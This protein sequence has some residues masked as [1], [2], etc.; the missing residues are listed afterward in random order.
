MKKAIRYLAEILF[1]VLALALYIMGRSSL[2]FFMAALIL[3]VVFEINDRL[4]DNKAVRNITAII[5]LTVV[6]WMFNDLMAI[7]KFHGALDK[8]SVL[9]FII[10]AIV[11]L[12]IFGISG[13]IYITFIISQIIFVFIGVLNAVIKA[14]RRTPISAGDIFSVKTAFAVAGN[15]SM[16]FDK[17]FVLKVGVGVVLVILANIIILSYIRKPKEQTI[18]L[19]IPTRII[20][21]AVPCIYVLIMA[22]TPLIINISGKEPDYFTHE[23][24]G[25]AFNLYLQLKDMVIK[26]PEDY[27]LDSLNQL[28]SEYTSDTAES[29]DNYPNIIVIMN[30]SFADL[31]VL[32][33][34]DTSQ[35]VLPFLNSLTENTI[36]GY[37]YSSVYGGNTANSEYE[38]LTGNS[39][40]YFSERVVP[41]QLY[42][43]ETRPSIVS[44]LEQLG[45]KTTFMHP[46]KAYSWNRPTVYTALGMDS[47]YYE[48]D[49]ADLE[50]LR[51]YATDS[52]QYDYLIKY[53][54]EEHDSPRFIYDVTVQNHGGY[55]EADDTL[56]K[57]TISGYEGQYP[58]TENYLTLVH[59]SDKA[60]QDLIEYLETYEE[61]TVVLFYGDHQPS[62][63]TSFVEMAEGKSQSD[64]TLED[65]QKMYK[66][67]F[68]LWANFDIEEKTVDKMSINYL[69]T[70][71]CNEIGLPMTGFQTFMADMYEELPVINSV[72]IIDNENENMSKGDLTGARADIF[73]IYTDLIYNYMFD[74]DSRMTEFF[75]LQ[76]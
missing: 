50:I 57:I 48:E 27:N 45:Y 6:M 32:G 74:S 39:I 63:E 60:I 52:S 59:E 64:F 3:F 42:M 13:K 22:A 26:E 56:E 4:I 33:D 40:S 15:Y 66:V 21:I 65:R 16:E 5:L 47:M 62:I 2:S 58:E 70:F 28:M 9:N 69:G 71:L 31:N 10:Y 17:E 11:F 14:I 75:T 54:N 36:K 38:F 24:N 12:L 19:A 68:F 44:Q 23:T 35:E 46:Y 61:P 41:F 67:P 30:E 25:F 1:V 18:K 20:C 43:N 37:L 29:S 73:D 76:E 53:L 72:G 7:G 51:G 49:M 55:T 8:I 34:F